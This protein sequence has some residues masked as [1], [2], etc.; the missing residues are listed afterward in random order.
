MDP[1]SDIDAIYAHGHGDQV[2]GTSGNDRIDNY[3]NLVTD[4]SKEQNNSGIIE[5]IEII[6]TDFPEVFS[7]ESKVKKAGKTVD[8]SN[9]PEDYYDNYYNGLSDFSKALYNCFKEAKDNGSLKKG[10]AEFEVIYRGYDSLEKAKNGVNKNEA[11]LYYQGMLKDV[12]KNFNNNLCF[13]AYAAFFWDNPDAYYIDS[14]RM[15]LVKSISVVNING[16]QYMYKASV[17]V[18]VK[19]VKGCLTYINYSYEGDGT[20][21]S[22]VSL[23]SSNNISREESEIAVTVNEIKSYI[24]EVIK[25]SGIKESDE[26]YNLKR[27]E[28]IVGALNDWLV[29]NNYYNKFVLY[30]KKTRDKA[31][32]KAWRMSSALTKQG[33]STE[34]I[35][36]GYK[37]F[38]DP[39]SPVCEGYSYAY[40]YLCNLY[41]I[42]CIVVSGMTNSGGT[43]MWNLIRFNGT[44][45][46]YAVDVT[47]NDYTSTETEKRKYFLCSKDTMCRGMTFSK[48]HIVTGRF[49]VNTNGFLVPSI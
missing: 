20:T 2:T 14:S 46:W 23:N 36:K 8:T 11:L 44:K 30:G 48:S 43:H 10:N 38:G 45:K 42:P 25:N 18:S 33:G 32:I 5:D 19:T 39:D 22:E 37:K 4:S 1:I 16:K 13:D 21:I 9:K 12:F 17:K 49:F 29:D 40:K 47:W 26:D 24:D 3:G 41:N 15:C 27:E 31:N 34:E 6:E 7:K 35:L 28:I